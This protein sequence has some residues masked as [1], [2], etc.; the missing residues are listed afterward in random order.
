MMRTLPRLA[1]SGTR[2]SNNLPVHATFIA[3][4]RRDKYRQPIPGI[5]CLR[6]K[7][8]RSRLKETREIAAMS[9]FRWFTKVLV[10]TWCDTKREAL[11]EA[12]TFGHAVMS[13]A[14][15]DIITL[16]PFVAIETRQ[17]I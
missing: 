6:D 7:C 13:P 1:K 17:R 5:W 4:G 12:L 3:T 10:G 8:L 9:Q 11:C 15:I 2:G 16:R 14:E